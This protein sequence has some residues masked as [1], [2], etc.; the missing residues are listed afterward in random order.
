MLKS[1]IRRDEGCLRNWLTLKY[2]QFGKKR[3]YLKRKYML[4]IIL[5]YVRYNTS[6]L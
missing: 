1:K 6:L 5:V 2:Q 3:S 4:D